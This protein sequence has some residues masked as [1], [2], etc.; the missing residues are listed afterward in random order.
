[1]DKYYPGER[2]QQPRTDKPFESPYDVDSSLLQDLIGRRQEAIFVQTLDLSVARTVPLELPLGCAIVLYGHDGS[3]IR[4]V[5]TT[6]F[7]W[8]QFNQYD[9]NQQALVAPNTM[10]SGGFPLKHS[11][12]FRGP[13]AKVFLTWPAQTGVFA[14]VVIHRYQGQPWINGES[15]T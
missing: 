9:P 14:D 11:R 12:G 4:T 5:N 2:F 10:V 15:A 8:A 6:A 13:F 3:S 1:M 7:A